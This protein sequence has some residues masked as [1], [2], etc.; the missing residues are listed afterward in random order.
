MTI[1]TIS[2]AV[3]SL[4]QT[5]FRVSEDVGLVELCAN[6]IFHVSDIPINYPIEIRLSTLDG[7]AGWLHSTSLYLDST[8]CY[9]YYV[10]VLQLPPWTMSHWM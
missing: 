6:I 4:E 2:G 7:V 8:Q 1:N 10:S 5:F 9:F 3:V